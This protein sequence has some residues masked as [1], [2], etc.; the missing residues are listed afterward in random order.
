[1]M[2]SPYLKL[3]GGDTLNEDGGYHT[4]HYLIFKK[5][6]GDTVYPVSAELEYTYT[7]L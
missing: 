6:N 7:Y 3:D 1:M 2:C 4:C 5:S